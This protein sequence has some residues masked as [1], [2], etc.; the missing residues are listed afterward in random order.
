MDGV[1][2]GVGSEARRLLDHLG[3]VLL[4]PGSIFSLQSLVSALVI[5]VAVLAW[6][7]R[8]RGKRLPSLRVL[9]RAIF[10]RRLFASGS[11]KA[12]FGF[13]LFNNYPAG[14][15]AFA[16]LSANQVEPLVVR[17]LARLCQPP[18][19]AMAAPLRQAL[20][21]LV[22]FA[23]YEFAYWLNHVM[24]H[25][26]PALWEF[27]KVHH[28]AESLSPLTVF[29]VHPVDSLVF[30]NTV[31]LIVGASAGVLAFLFDQVSPLNLSG[32]NALMV[33]ALFL[34]LHLQHSHVWISFQGLAGRL[35]LSPAHHQIHHSTDPRH[36]NRNFGGCLA[37]WDWMFG[38]L[39]VPQRGRERLTF[40]AETTPGVLP[41]S[42]TGTLITPFIEAAKTLA[43]R[44]RA[45]GP[46]D[47]GWR[48][49]LS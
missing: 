34:V 10:P 37:I 4:S 38:T 31:A 11:G 39:H 21:T 44:P 32:T 6:R 41:H 45:A 43:P 46:K 30:I 12:D 25:R 36:F 3:D 22:L 13:F 9:I 40:G 35:V 29:R 8:A 1:L 19:L 24:S 14:A 2:I 17:L 26:I 48:S 33:A 20:D 7:R 18:H 5:A 23:A 42:V 49:E 15:L 47:A 16:I 28:T 27:H